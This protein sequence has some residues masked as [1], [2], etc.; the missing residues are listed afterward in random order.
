MTE[1]QSSDPDAKVH[2]DLAVRGSSHP[3]LEE[4]AGDLCGPVHLGAVL[5]GGLLGRIGTGPAVAVAKPTCKLVTGFGETR[6][7][8]SKDRLG[9]RSA[10]S[11]F[12]HL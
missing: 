4:Y 7:A 1:L 12:P 2:P 3:V 10:Q 9:H 11:A 8:G 5:H 6:H